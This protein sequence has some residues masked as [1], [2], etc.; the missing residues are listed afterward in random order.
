MSRVVRIAAALAFTGLPLSGQE[1]DT[2][3][4]IDTTAKGATS[5]KVGIGMS[6][7]PAGILVFDADVFL[8]LPG[9]NNFYIPIKTG[10]RTY[11]EPEFG[12]FRSSFN[13][14]GGG[15]SDEG[16]L[17]NIRLGVG[18]LMEM[19]PR[20]DLRPYIGPRV[21]INRTSSKSTSGSTSSSK[22]TSWF[23]SGVLG[24]Q[25]FLAPHFSLGGEVQLTRTSVGNPS[26]DPPSGGEVTQSFITSQSLL[27]LR[28]YF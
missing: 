2:T 11:I 14:S 4:R 19:R 7:N 8:L 17:T 21:G 15:F 12:V 9:F 22:Q 6:L 25:Y 26:E 1:P 18:V 20:G 27:M 10:E 3:T 13:A 5:A 16:S 24:A 23:L 28:W